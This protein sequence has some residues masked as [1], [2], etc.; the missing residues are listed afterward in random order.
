MDK[1]REFLSL[2]KFGDIQDRRCGY[3]TPLINFHLS[4][5]LIQNY[6]KYK[7][8]IPN[9]MIFWFQNRFGSSILGRQG[10]WD[11]QCQRDPGGRPAVTKL[12]PAQDPR[13]R[14]LQQSLKNR[15]N[16]SIGGWVWKDVS[17]YIIYMYICL[18]IYIYTIIH[19][20]IVYK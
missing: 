14:C 10:P 3:L 11:S 7:H 9:P 20:Y 1:I 16:Q 2:V 5:L 17:Y 12:G 8:V 19:T 18:Y 4:F 13:C 15:Q 6:S